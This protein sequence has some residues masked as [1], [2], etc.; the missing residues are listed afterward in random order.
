MT[1]SAEKA[2][3]A[4]KKAVVKDQDTGVEP[5]SDTD[6]DLNNPENNL[7]QS[8][9][10]LAVAA[11]NDPS[12]DKVAREQAERSSTHAN[13]PTADTD[14]PVV[15]DNLVDLFAAS[16]TG[17]NRQGNAYGIS[18]DAIENFRRD[19][20]RRRDE[21]NLELEALESQL[22][23]YE[24]QLSDMGDN[25]NLNIAKEKAAEESGDTENNALSGA[26]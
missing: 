2:T 19:A 3:G 21:I 15:K 9:D 17:P 14:P 23:E 6:A 20:E 24:S 11:K 25:V 18:R 13:R 12:S 26:A 1:P 10:D 8:D 5:G 4:T 16:D 22:S 7:N